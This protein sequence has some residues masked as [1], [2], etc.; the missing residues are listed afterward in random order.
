MVCLFS[1]SGYFERT[2]YFPKTGLVSRDYQ[3]SDCQAAKVS[4][5]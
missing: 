4:Y 3:W 5:L 1:A 2:R